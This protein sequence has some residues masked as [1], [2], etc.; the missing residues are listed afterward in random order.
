[1]ESQRGRE[2]GARRIGSVDNQVQR[3]VD[4]INS[5]QGPSAGSVNQNITDRAIDAVLR[6]G[7]DNQFEAGECESGGRKQTG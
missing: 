4:S 5:M 1:M 7:M 2:Q 3:V 6:H